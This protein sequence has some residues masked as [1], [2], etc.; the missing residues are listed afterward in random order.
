M[1]GANA[2]AIRKAEDRDLFRRRW[3]RS[4]SSPRARRRQYL[5]DARRG[6]AQIGLPAI[7]RPAFTLGGTGGGIAYNGEE[8]E[9][10]VSRGLDRS[11]DHRGPRRGVAARLEGVRD[12]GDARP[13]RT[14]C[15]IICSIENFDPMGVHTGDSIT[16]A[17]PQTL[18]DKEYQIMR[19]ARST[20][21]REIGVETAAPTVQ[22]AI[23]PQ[24]R[25][26]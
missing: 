25:A 12:G 16:V 2:D 18:T 21:M 10:I 14:T 13:A 26:A 5:D 6:L 4:G 3:T 19:N 1:I 7:I 11:P 22:F 9:T 24:D 23:D 17:P 15:V 8:F 20:I